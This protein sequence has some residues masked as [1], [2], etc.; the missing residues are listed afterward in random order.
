MLR[1][2]ASLVVVTLPGGAFLVHPPGWRDVRPAAVEVVRYEGT[3]S[4]RG[5]GNA[6]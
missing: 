6:L 1:K 5:F 3:N 4:P 2:I